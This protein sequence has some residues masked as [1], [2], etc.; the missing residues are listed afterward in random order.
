MPGERIDALMSG[1]F[2]LPP[3]GLFGLIDLIGL[4]VMDL[5]G[6]NLAIN[7]PAG[8]AGRAFAGF[9]EPVQAMLERGQL[10]RKS[11][12]GFYRMQRLDDGSKLKE[13][14]DLGTGDWRTAEAVALPDSHLGPGVMLLDDADGR[15][16][17]EIM[18]E[19][20]CYAAGLVPEIADDIVS[21]DRAMR[22]GFAWRQGPF[23][24]LDALGADKVIGKL[25]RAGRELPHMLRVLKEAG[26][27]TFYRSEGSRFLGTD[28]RF[29]SVPPE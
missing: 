9:P 2:G 21:V 7:L 11:G 1:P 12:G 4:D 20:L 16:A 19:T 24:L 3:T 10:G 29:H 25:G 6:K 26:A 13:T 8:D 23:E 14:F 17:W 5:V 28:G 27:E 15:L 18:G 22:L